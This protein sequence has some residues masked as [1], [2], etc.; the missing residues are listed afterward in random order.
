M[1]DDFLHKSL[2]ERCSHWLTAA[3]LE[4]SCSKNQPPVIHFSAGTRGPGHSHHTLAV[5][6]I[7]RALPPQWSGSTRSQSGCHWAP[8]PRDT[9][10]RDPWRMSLMRALLKSP[11][12]GFP[13]ILFEPE[14]VSSGENPL[15]IQQDASTRMVPPAVV[16][17]EDLQ[18]DYPGPRPGSSGLAS[19]HASA[20]L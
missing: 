9:L 4:L 12:H 13:H 7:L 17:G 2:L 19:D 14:A 8:S 10:N 16:V 3:I 6:V 11:L 5:T 18:A 20:R 15:G 1:N